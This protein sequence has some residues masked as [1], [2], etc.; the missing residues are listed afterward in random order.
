MEGLLVMARSHVRP[1]PFRLF[2]PWGGDARWA[3]RVGLWGKLLWKLASKLDSRGG[4]GLHGR[5]AAK[6]GE[7]VRFKGLV[8]ASEECREG[9]W[10][11]LCIFRALCC[12]AS[13]AHD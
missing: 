4:K 7:L 3:E 1:Y 6:S 9:G 8:S 11:L 2:D 12:L 5:H 10:G 13:A